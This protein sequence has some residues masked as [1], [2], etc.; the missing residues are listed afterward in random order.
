MIKQQAIVAGVNALVEQD[1]LTRIV[2]GQDELGNDIYGDYYKYYKS[3]FTVD[4]NKE[5]E[6]ALVQ[7]STDLKAY[8]AT[9]IGCMAVS[10]IIDDEVVLF[11]GKPDAV[12]NILH[13]I[14][15]LSGDEIT[16]W[17]VYDN[18]FRVVNQT[19][20]GK[21]L[22]KA[23]IVKTMLKFAESKVAVDEIV[24]YHQEWFDKFNKE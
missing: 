10:A 7:Q 4:M 15:A 11:D 19:I 9:A 20:L 14:Q 16:Q 2:V 21:V 24:S 1:K 23:G 17:V 8:I 12:T 3:D 13:A 6:I 18:S 5:N 22:R